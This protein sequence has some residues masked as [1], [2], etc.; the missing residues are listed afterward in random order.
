MQHAICQRIYDSI[1][2]AMANDSFRE[3]PLI[4]NENGSM[5]GDRFEKLGNKL[6]I[7]N[8]TTL[9]LVGVIDATSFSS[10][11]DIRALLLYRSN[12]LFYLETGGWQVSL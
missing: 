5:A 2:S 6:G 4:R 1:C 7:R 10:G 11:K 9:N 8:L 12:S 3:L